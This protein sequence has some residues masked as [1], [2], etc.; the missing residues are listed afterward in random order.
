[1][2]SKSTENLLGEIKDAKNTGELGKYLDEN[3]GDMLGSLRYR[4]ADLLS[5]KDKSRKEVMERGGLTGYND[6]IFNGRRHPSRD[7]LIRVILGLELNIDEAQDLL[8][9]ATHKALDPRDPRDAVIV[10]CINSRMSGTD[11]D[12]RL[13]KLGF[14][15]LE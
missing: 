3:K 7:K 8:R 13:D 1:M 14:D 5:Q 15:P 6:Q 12:L 11:T 4:L 2:T 10:S 9:L